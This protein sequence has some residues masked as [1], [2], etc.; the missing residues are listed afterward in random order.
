MNLDMGKEGRVQ[1]TK[2]DIPARNLLRLG[3]D[4]NVISQTTVAC[5]LKK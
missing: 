4:I 3:V 2:I 1:R 5:N